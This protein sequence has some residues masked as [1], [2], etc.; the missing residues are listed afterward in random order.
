[1]AKNPERLV[2]RRPQRPPT[3]KSPVDQ[4]ALASTDI[5]RIVKLPIPLV[6]DTR[7]PI[8]GDFTMTDYVEAQDRIVAV[9]TAFAK[10][11]SKLREA[12][13]NDPRQLFSWLSD[14]A[15]ADMARK[16]G[17]GVG[18]RPEPPPEP[19][20]GDLVTEAV[21]AGLNSSNPPKGG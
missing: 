6:A 1:M 2:P 17:I 7:T 8:Y 19:S 3:G 15:N 12:M 16:Y 21:K 5:N 10:L 20:L 4:S 13:D 14:S 11:P 18:K 9:K